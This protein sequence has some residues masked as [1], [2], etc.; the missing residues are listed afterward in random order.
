MACS[1]GR[2][3]SPRNVDSAKIEADFHDGVIEVHMPKS[4]ESGGKHIEIK[5]H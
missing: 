2:S 4:K 3:P 1:S 5:S